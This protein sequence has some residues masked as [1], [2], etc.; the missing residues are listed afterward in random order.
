M[1]LKDFIK[2]VITDITDAVSELQADLKN[3]L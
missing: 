2:N 3:V 1:E